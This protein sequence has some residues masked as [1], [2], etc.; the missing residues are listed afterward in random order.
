MLAGQ[1]VGIKQ[2]DE[3]AWLATFMQYDLGFFD[4]ETCRLEPGKN[5]FEAAVLP[6]SPV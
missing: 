6:M 1:N 3:H 5:P 2:V 4:D